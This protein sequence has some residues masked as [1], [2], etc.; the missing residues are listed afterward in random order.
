MKLPLIASPRLLLLTGAFCTVLAS[1]EAQL[2]KRLSDKAKEMVDQRLRNTERKAEDAVERKIDEAIDRGT[3]QALGRGESQAKSGAPATGAFSPFGAFAL[4][5]EIHYTFNRQVTYKIQTK[6]P[7]QSRAEEISFSLLY[8]EGQTYMGNKVVNHSGRAKGDDAMVVYD[9]KN[10]CMVIFHDGA[11]GRRSMALPWGMD[12][13]AATAVDAN[14]EASRPRTEPAPAAGMPGF[15][16][17]GTKV[18]AGYTC[19][20]YRSGDASSR[21]EMWMSEEFPADLRRVLEESRA[22]SMLN[23]FMPQALPMGMLLEIR[24]ENS[25]TGESMVMTLTGV[26]SETLTLRLADY[27]RAM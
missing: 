26:S 22:S 15:E 23:T 12:P 13:A 24:S 19:N 10:Q 18:I 5:P 25:K 27:P 16:R 9:A 2:L 14:P 1:A 8:A 11:D 7:K 21:V 17:I 4:N 6:A 3:D 20:G